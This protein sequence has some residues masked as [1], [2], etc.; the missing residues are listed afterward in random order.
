MQW[1]MDFYNNWRW[2][3]QWLDLEEAPKHFPKPNLLQKKV[4]VT[5]WWSAAC[6]IYYNFLNPKKT[7]TSEKYAQQIDEMH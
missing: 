2:P 5:V 6:L 1:K 4:L 7:V 3:S